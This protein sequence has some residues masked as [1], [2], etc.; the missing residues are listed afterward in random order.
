MRAAVCALVSFLTAVLV[1]AAPA[2]AQELSPAELR[3]EWV[4]F[5]K[6]YD[7]RRVVV[8]DVRPAEAFEAGHIPG[9]MSVPLDDVESRVEALKKAGKPI[10]LYCA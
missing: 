6:A 7:T 4:E 5:K 10:V 1:P 9:A 8:V 3:V 2:I